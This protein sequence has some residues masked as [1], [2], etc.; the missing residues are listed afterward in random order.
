M[1]TYKAARTRR[2]KVKGYRHPT[3]YSGAKI[4]WRGLRAKAA[5]ADF[6][7]HDFRHDVATKLLRNTGNLKLIQRALNHADLKTTTRY[8]HVN[9]DEVAEALQ[10]VHD[11]P[12]K[13]QAS[14]EGRL[15]PM[16]PMLSADVTISLGDWES[17]V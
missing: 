15:T 6:R 13:S 8:A 5:V 9:S 2:S 14:R 10:R 1:F 16:K 12:K 11:S 3:T 4:A 17:S 7:F